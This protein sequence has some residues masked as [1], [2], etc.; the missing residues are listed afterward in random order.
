M[1]VFSLGAG[2][3]LIGEIVWKGVTDPWLLAK[4]LRRV[5]RQQQ[6][7]PDGS[8]AG[9]SFGIADLDLIEDGEV[10]LN[11]LLVAHIDQ[12]SISSR[13]RYAEMYLSFMKERE[14]FQV[15]AR[16][17][18]AG[19]TLPDGGAPIPPRRRG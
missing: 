1:A 12:M 19:L 7:S 18:E 16:A 10:N 11:P 15:R 2:E 6:R 13:L 4:N 8:T 14:A 5:I 9:F 3:S 17:E